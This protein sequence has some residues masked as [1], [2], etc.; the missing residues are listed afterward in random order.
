MANKLKHLIAAYGQV[1]QQNQDCV[2]ATIIET[3]GSTYQ[4]AG[5]RM[6]I[7]PAGEMIGVLGGG[8]FEGDLLEHARTVFKTGIAKSVFYDMRLADD[9]V[10]GLGLGCKGAVRI[11]LQLVQTETGFSPLDIFAEIDASKKS[12]V[13]VSV[14]ESAHPQ[15]PAGKNLF[16]PLANSDDGQV[17]ASSIFPFTSAAL[18]TALQQK[19]RIASYI[20]EG[21]EIKAFYDPLQASSR[22]LVFGAGADAIPLSQFAKLLGWQVSIVDH[23]PAYCNKE[24]FPQADDLLNLL[25]EDL[26]TKLELNQFDA[27]ILM[28]HNLEYDQRYLKALVNCQ[29]PFIG[30]LGPSHRKDKL[31]QALGSE[32]AQLSQRIFGPIGLDIGAETP[33]EIALSI[34]AGIYAELNGRS[35]HTL[36]VPTISDGH[37]YCHC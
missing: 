16:L 17:L 26:G 29:I 10:W 18:Q 1:K 13:L 27:A 7:N 28:T 37:E 15:F 22:L 9:L 36:N 24:R 3:F 31:M 12:G 19:A 25:P 5:A 35:G 14:Y 30:L 32:T 34:M 8:C 33:E 21:Q 20:V 2:L 4:K 6:L 23:R 11:L